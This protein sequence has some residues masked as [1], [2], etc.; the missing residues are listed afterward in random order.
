MVD[1]PERTTTTR[2]GEGADITLDPVT[3]A[4]E[5]CVILT[6][7]DAELHAHNLRDVQAAFIQAAEFEQKRRQER[8]AIAFYCRAE[9]C[10]ELLELINAG[11]GTIETEQALEA[12]MV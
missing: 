3:P 6:R 12:V 2:P 8:R 9:L 7:E 11:L 10:G 5:I 1:T 4:G